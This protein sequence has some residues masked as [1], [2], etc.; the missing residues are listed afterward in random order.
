MTKNFLLLFTFVSISFSVCGKPETVIRQSEESITFVVDENLPSPQRQIKKR[1]GEELE[2]SI[3][4]DS[5]TS[6]KATPTLASSF[7]NDTFCY[8][9][10][11]AFFN[12]MVKAY[13]DHRPVIL[14]PDMIWLLISQGFCHYVNENPE[15]MREKIV[16]HKDKK[17][18]T[19]QS[20]YDVYSPEVR[21]DE[22]VNGFDKQIAANTKGKLAQTMVADFTTTG[23]VEHTV[24]EMTLMSTVKSYF[25]FLVIYAS[26]GIPYITLEGTT[27][28]WE[29]VLARTK[30]LEK[31]G[32]EWWTADLIPILEEFVK[33]SKGNINTSFWK[34]IVKRQNVTDLKGGGC[35]P[36]K[37][38]M[39]DGW[40]LKLMPYS[41]KGRTPAEVTHYYDDIIPQIV[42]VDFEYMLLSPSG[43]IIKQVPMEMWAGFVGADIDSV[44]G[45][46]RPKLGWL[47]RESSSEDDMIKELKIK[48]IWEDL[49]VKEIPEILK[50]VDYMP[51]LNINFDDKIILP[52][53][54]GNI[55]IDELTFRGNFSSGYIDSV[56]V[57]FPDR[58]IEQL[59]NSAITVRSN[60]SFAPSDYI[61]YGRTDEMENCKF[62][63]GYQ[64]L[65]KFITKNRR[66]NAET[67]TDDNNDT[68]SRITVVKFVVEKDGSLS[69]IEAKSRAGNKEHEAEALR[70]FSIMPK[71]LP[72]TR[73]GMPVRIYSREIMRF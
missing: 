70:I 60:T 53:W 15:A 21:W 61:Y 63:G 42:T 48:A 68:F 71:W 30:V 12:T 46:I 58:T 72:A 38:T 25:D 4:Y 64:E 41:E 34:S 27:A 62:P 23:I 11:S 49:Q 44:S 50:K 37:P 56:K 51:V 26:C 40:F 17:Q 19:V 33:A 59:G 31:Y 43:E 36:D 20:P 35:S 28:D 65:Q 7:H 2:K 6:N 5:K 57:L 16:S 10:T 39:L 47:I 69:N 18:L 9:G 8:M 22:I 14:S 45:A 3:V 1:S 24:S 52:K 13:A 32:M 29:S 54:I 66:I 73:K 55:K 67:N